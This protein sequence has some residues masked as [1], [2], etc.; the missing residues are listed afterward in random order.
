LTWPPVY[1]KEGP[2]SMYQ[3]GVAGTVGSNG[4]HIAVVDTSAAPS[5]SPASTTPATGPLSPD[6]ILLER[7]AQYRRR[8]EG[9]EARVRELQ[10]EWE[11]KVTHN[12]TLQKRL[13][14]LHEQ[15]DALQPSRGRRL[16]MRAIEALLPPGTRRRR[17]A[18]QLRGSV[19]RRLAPRDGR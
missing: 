18:K 16:T 14:A 5:P 12:V 1:W 13:D 6:A 7:I 8:I 15:L 9:L 19:G 11:F 3:C 4:T 10:L 17:L 2:D